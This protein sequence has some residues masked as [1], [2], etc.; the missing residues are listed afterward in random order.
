MKGRLSAESKEIVAQANRWTLVELTLAEL[1]APAQFSGIAWQDATGAPQPTFYID[2]LAFIDLDLS[3]TPTPAPVAGPDL[4]V[5]LEAERHPINPDIYGINYADEMLATALNLPVRRWGGNA[6]TRYNWQNDTANR[7]SDWFFENIPEENENPELL[8]TGSAADRFVEQDQRTGTK[9][10]LTIPMIG[11]TP[12]SR[13]RNLRP[14]A[15]VRRAM[16]PQQ[17]SDPWQTECGNGMT[18]DGEPIT[19]NDPTDTSMPI[20][21]TFVQEWMA[22]LLDRFG[23][24]AEGASPI[25]TLR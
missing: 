9:T 3:P 1:G 5:N 17:E 10:L 4:R 7:A 13:E 12:K 15:K 6:T 22:H 2:D 25:A 21:P 8:P 11:W 16:G 24:A 19:G 20:D 18:T 23:T 14:F